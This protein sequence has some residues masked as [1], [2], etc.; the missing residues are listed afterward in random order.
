MSQLRVSTAPVKSE[1]CIEKADYVACNKDTYV[2]KFDLTSNLK[3]GGI[4]VLASSWDVDKMT[5][6]FPASLKRDIARRGI[7]LYN[8]D[9]ASIAHAVGL[10]ER[11]NTIMETV[12]FKLMPVI[13]FDTAYADLKQRISTVY[14]HEGNAVVESNL[15]AISQ[16]VGAI[17]PVVVPA[18]WADA[19]DAP[20]A[21]ADQLPEFVAKVA[22]SRSGMSTN[23]SNAPSAPS[24][25]PTRQSAPI[26]SMLRSVPKLLRQ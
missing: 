25:A 6:I 8:V 14:R 16:A 9:A 5:E 20:E 21:T 24:Y 19:V 10:G 15:A 4:L 18:G 12:F 1:Y 22:I 17:T 13:P 11:I 26:C 7:K 23:V 2:R 3:A